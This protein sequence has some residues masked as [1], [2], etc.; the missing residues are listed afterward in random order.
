MDNRDSI[1]LKV[2]ELEKEV[3][4]LRDSVAKLEARVKVL[5][6]RPRQIVRVESK[7]TKP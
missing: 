5:A 3:K 2:W 1:V 7:L 4:R 6:R